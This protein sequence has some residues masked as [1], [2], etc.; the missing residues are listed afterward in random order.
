MIVSFGHNV[1][2]TWKKT[3]TG[4]LI[5]REM[6][7]NIRRRRKYCTSLLSGCPS[8]VRIWKHFSRKTN[9]PGLHQTIYLSSMTLVVLHSTYHSSS[10]YLNN[11][12]DMSALLNTR[13]L[14]I[15]SEWIISTL[16]LNYANNK[17]WQLFKSTFK[18]RLAENNTYLQYCKLHYVFAIFPIC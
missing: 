1:G 18:A 4:L 7:H 15:N 16:T 17:Y 14:I 9:A 6:F 8:F 10:D 5:S 3:C 11:E 12:K 2:R 13:P